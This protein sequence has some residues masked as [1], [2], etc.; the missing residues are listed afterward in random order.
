MKLFEV[1]YSAQ[2]TKKISE[3]DFVYLL[4]KNCKQSAKRIN[5]T[6]LYRGV[7]KDLQ[8]QFGDT[9]VGSPRKSANTKNYYTLWVDN[10]P[11]WKDFPKRSR[12]FI[13]TTDKEY[14]SSFG[15][16]YLVIPFDNAQIGICP[17]GDF[18]FSFEGASD[19]SRLNN[20]IDGIFS[21][22]LDLEIVNYGDTNNIDSEDYAFLK[23]F[24][25]EVTL[26]NLEKA[27]DNLD[28]KTGSE[29][30]RKRTLQTIY[31]RD[32]EYL[33]NKNNVKNFSDAMD[34]ILSPKKFIKTDGKSFA[35]SGIVECFVGGKVLF[36]PLNFSK[37]NEHKI[38]KKYLDDNHLNN[39]LREFKIKNV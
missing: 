33:I 29:W 6:P 13:C 21:T 20:I 15:E 3:E 32:A 11:M 10:S 38:L 39:I 4:E 19:L 1:A 36:L 24:L 17:S 16:I 9:S 26:Q 5:A 23:N 31:I 22:F 30:I 35:A 37:N 25:K 14:A 28:S 18:W 27:K 12:S 34:A 8:L 7:D 2:R